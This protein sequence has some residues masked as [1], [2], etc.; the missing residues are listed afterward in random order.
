MSKTINRFVDASGRR[1]GGDIPKGTKF[2][3][4]NLTEDFCGHG[5]AR[6]G[7]ELTLVEDDGYDCPRFRVE[8]LAKSKKSSLWYFDLRT[9]REILDAPSRFLVAGSNWD[10]IPGLR[11][12]PGTR[13]RLKKDSMGVPAGAILVATLDDGSCCPEFKLED[14]SLWSASYYGQG[15]RGYYEDLS[16]LEEIIET[17]TPA[18]T[19]KPV[20]KVGD[21]V[22]TETDVGNDILAGEAY[23]VT[24]VEGDYIK[25]V[26]SGNDPRS[27]PAKHY[28]VVP[29]PT[30]ARPF[31]VGDQVREKAT[32][33]VGVVVKDDKSDFLPFRVKFD[34]D[35][36]EDF[37]WFFEHNLELVVQE[38]LDQLCEDEGCD[39][40][41][42]PHVC[43]SR[44]LE[45]DAIFA[46]SHY[47]R[48][49][50]QPKDFITQNRLTYNVGTVV[51][52][53]CR[54]DAKNGL[55]DLLKAR[56][57]LDYLIEA[58]RGRP[59]SQKAMAA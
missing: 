55:E 26:D 51:S 22:S 8:R 56:E 19:T 38:T 17:P 32:G 39:H 13:F 2:V 10:R 42:T 20:I 57:H 15:G 23:R 44:T 45:P 36:G 24:A 58:E 35:V 12:E 18:E 47:A 30:E 14:P 43:V 16:S 11:V 31:Q 7:D 41:G 34:T 4:E 3:V 27:R 46:P 53:L 25:F 40:F 5:F 54:F 49:S 37:E 48:F 29:A 59:G 52:Y 28:K 1:V 21:W 33:K 50:I 9:L 6:N